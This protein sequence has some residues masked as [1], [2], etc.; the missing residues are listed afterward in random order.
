LIALKAAL[1]NHPSKANE[2]DIYYHIGLSYA[3]E[4]KFE[5]AVF[6][7]TKCIER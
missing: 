3:R 5:K 4:E 7:F 1:K 2:P 6:P